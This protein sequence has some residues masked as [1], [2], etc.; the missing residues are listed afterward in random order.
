M[1]AYWHPLFKTT[2]LV[3]FSNIATS[4]PLFIPMIYGYVVVIFYI[5]D[6][7][8]T[9]TRQSAVEYAH[10][11]FCNYQLCISAIDVGLLGLLGLGTAILKNAIIH[12]YGFDYI[13]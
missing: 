8:S 5:L 9:V 4:R 10:C 6:Q 13:I 1:V 3:N 11:S 12:R 2:E 7:R